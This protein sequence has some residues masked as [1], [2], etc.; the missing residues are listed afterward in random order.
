MRSFFTGR[1]GSLVQ[2][3]V[4]GNWSGEAQ[5]EKLATE[6]RQARLSPSDAV[7]LLWLRERALRAVGVEVFV[8]SAGRS[9]VRDLVERLEE[10]PAHVRG[11][12]TRLFGRLDVD[13]MRGV[14]EEL[15]G[16]K[17]SKRRRMVWEVALGLAEPLKSVYLKRAL[18]EA[19]IALRTTALQR[20]IQG[21]QAERHTGLLIELAESGDPRLAVL[22]LEAVSGVIAPEVSALMVRVFASPDA[23]IRSVAVAYLR[24]AAAQAPQAT[25]TTMLELLG[26]GEDSTRRLCVEILLETGDTRE[27]IVQ[28]LVFSSELVGWLRDRILETLQT[29]GDGVLEPALE[30]LSHPDEQIR[31]AALVLAEGFRDPRLV[32]PLVGLLDNPDWWLRIIACDALGRLGDERAVTPLIAALDD[33]DT[34]WAAVDALA[35]IGSVRAIVPLT[36]LLRN[37]RLEVRRDVV[38]AFGQF[39]D[40]R[41]LR[42]L[43]E[44]QKKDPS[45]EIRTLASEVL[46][47]M[48][49][50][51]NVH[52]DVVESGTVAVASSSLKS[53]V[54]RLLASIRELGASDLHLAVGEPPWIRLNGQLH[55]MDMG[56]LTARQ[57]EASVLGTL[58]QQ[59]RALLQEWGQVDYCYAIP[60]VGR[61]RANA[62]RER[63]GLSCAFRVIPNLPPTFADLRLPGHL[64]E[65]LDYHQGIVLVSGPAGSGKST[66]LAAIVNLINRS[67]RSHVLTLEDPIEFV[68]PV[69]V[70]LVNQREVT[71]RHSRS[72]ARALRGGLR[73]DPD[74]IVVG[75]LKDPETIRMALEA[76]ETGHLVIAT[77]NTTSAVQTLDRLVGAFPPEEHASVRM[78]LSESCKYIISQQ[79]V[80]RRDQSGRVAVFEIL[81][82]TPALETLI[83]DGKSFQ[84]PGMMEVGRRFGM[85]TVDHAL[86]DLVES[87]LITPE[88]AWT[89]AAR[90]ETFETLCDPEF[91]AGVDGREPAEE[92]DSP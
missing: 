59:Q 87:E 23:R 9:D 11:Y 80:E 28:I 91:L 27:V 44:V 75:Q 4:R 10:K 6:L 78:A 66:T 14:V 72:F 21:G 19:P 36:A 69:K 48:A 92:E 7:E 51:L 45:S 81:K 85:Q 88:A 74:I 25:R 38:G 5:L 79:L 17:D 24:R 47:D 63:H 1:K 32:E 43:L 65:L 52:M 50:R 33:E 31:T 40:K 86:M 67:K 13:L 68:H 30:L 89:R 39:T 60:E 70:A 54:D 35:T 3:A 56:A 37:P 84:I 42:L 15:V 12:V 57:V 2:D 8:A 76:A 55:R 34:R 77:M 90:P 29:F 64:T 49:A 61:Y 41:L 16:H 58:S 46:R 20:L 26:G 62:Y 22:A 53:P 71:G 82:N 83:R 18:V 73:E